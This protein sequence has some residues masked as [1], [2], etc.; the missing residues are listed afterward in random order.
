M[1][2][3][4]HSEKRNRHRSQMK[5]PRINLGS[6]VNEE[7]SVRQNISQEQKR[8]TAN[9]LFSRNRGWNGNGIGTGRLDGIFHLPAN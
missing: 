7:I 4:N 1:L 8:C 3:E 2:E 9:L 6:R 5:I